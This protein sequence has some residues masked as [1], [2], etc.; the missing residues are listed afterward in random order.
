VLVA[1]PKTDPDVG[2][3]FRRLADAAY[4]PTWYAQGQG[5]ALG[6]DEQTAAVKTAIHAGTPGV[7]HADS[8][9]RTFL[10]VTHNKFKYSNTLLSDPPTEAFHRTRVIFDIE[11][12]QRKVIDANGCVVIRY[13]YD[14][15][16][17]EKDEDTANNRIHQA[18]MEAGERR[19]LND[20]AGKPIY[21]WDSQGHQFHTTY[22][23]LRRPTESFLREGAG[24][25]LL[26][27]RSVYGETQPNPEDNNLRGQVVQLFDQAGV[28]TSDDYDFKGNLRRSQRQLAQA[29]NATLNWPTVPLEADIY[30]SRTHYDALNRPTELTAPDNSVIRDEEGVR[31]QGER[32]WYVYDAGGQRVRKV[33][34]RQNG[35]RKNERTYL[36]GFEKYREY[37]G[38]G[39]SVTLERETLHVMDDEQRIALVETRTTQGNDGSPE[40]LIR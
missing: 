38:N 28:V 25:E 23:P 20:V 33:T 29:Y 24:A 1:D 37:D 32:T 19:M 21:A 6:P 18:S 10:T 14:I 7:T 36:G 5:E 13:D 11:G 4:L 34:E 8:L 16:G 35:T 27:E 9:G 40:Q 12:N 22:D 26:A 2:N 17:P 30:T 15:A 39:T 31:S 3:Y